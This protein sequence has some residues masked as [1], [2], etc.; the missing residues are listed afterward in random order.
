MYLT[1]EQLGPILKHHWFTTQTTESF[2]NYTLYNNRSQV[3]VYTLRYNLQSPTYSSDTMI[4]DMI[5]KVMTQFPKD[6]S[7]VCNIQYDMLLVSNKENEVSYYLWRANS[8][9]HTATEDVILPKEY[10]KLYLFG[11]KATAPDMNDLNVQFQSSSVV[12][13][14]LLT[15]V[16]TFSPLR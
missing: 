10:D 7:L 1:T 2:V 5:T 11:K 12:I 14:K 9:Q 6:E 4:E 13:A 15:F 8:N 3:K 16:F